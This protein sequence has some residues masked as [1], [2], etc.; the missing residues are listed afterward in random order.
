MYVCMVQLYVHVDERDQSVKLVLLVLVLHSSG[1][2]C[3]IYIGYETY[4]EE[5]GKED[6]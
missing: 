6:N 3:I 4:G 5:R 2:V 1:G